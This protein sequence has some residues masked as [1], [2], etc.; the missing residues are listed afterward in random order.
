MSNVIPFARDGRK[1]HH[2]NS[3]KS[4]AIP[5][6]VNDIFH[7]VFEDVMSHWQKYAVRNRLNEFISNKIP[8]FIRGEG[9]ADYTSDLNALSAIELKLEM[10]V[11]LFWPGGTTAN[12]YGWIA[13]FHKDDNIF[14]TPADMSSEAN[15]RALNI[16]L[17]LT[18]DYQLKNV[19]GNLK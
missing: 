6:S 5:I 7:E 8:S 18:L 4:L 19:S 9:T 3:D 14:T 17:Y 15:A 13:G 12:P 2:R 1:P 10:R 11:T 16:L